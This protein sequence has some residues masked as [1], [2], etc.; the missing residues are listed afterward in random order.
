MHPPYYRGCWHGVSRC[1]LLGYRQ[2][3]G[4]FTPQPS[5][6]MTVVYNPRTFFPHAVLLDQGFPHCPIF[7]TAASRRS[8]GRV[9]VPVWL[10]VLS[11]QLPVQALV[12]RYLT[13]KLMGRK[14]ILSRDHRSEGLFPKRTFTIL[15]AYRELAPLSRSCPRQKGR[16]FTCYAPVRHFTRSPKGTF[17]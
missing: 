2:D 9:S 5:S 3:T 13:N 15:K 14:S 11:D 1:F 17:S 4:L 10:I 7:P 8:L 6:P 12:S 16:L